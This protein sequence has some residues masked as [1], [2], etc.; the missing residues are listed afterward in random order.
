MKLPLHPPIYGPLWAGMRLV[1]L[2]GRCI[3]CLLLSIVCA[4]A[5]QPL[6]P[7]PGSAFRKFPE[8][9]TQPDQDADITL[10]ALPPES[11]RALQ[12]TGRVLLRL[13]QAEA[14]ELNPHLRDDL[15]IAWVTTLLAAREHADPHV[16][17]SYKI[18]G[19]HP[20]QV[21]AAH[22]ARRRAKLGNHYSS[23]YDEAGNLRPEDLAKLFA[24]GSSPKKPVQSVRLP[25]SEEREG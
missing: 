4:T 3:G 11:A 18:L 24:G 21:A 13:E 10:E 16:N 9:L 19:L 1:R 15:R 14:R 20:D 17:A 23:F 2:A 7:D 12:L 22:E 6:P 25:R 8:A 5:F